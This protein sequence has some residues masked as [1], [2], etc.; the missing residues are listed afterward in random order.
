MQSIRITNNSV[1]AV[2]YGYGLAEL[3]GELTVVYLDLAPQHPKTLGAIWASLVNGARE[4]LRLVDENTGA[5]H[6]VRGLHRRYHRLAADA[7]RI[8]SRARPKHLRL[9]AP[10]ACQVEKLTHPF[11]ALSWSWH[12]EADRPQQLCPAQ[13]LA[14]ML[15][16]S[17]PLPIR[18]GWGEYLLA[19][20]QALD[21][22]QPVQRGGDSPEGWVIQ[23]APWDDI[24]S[25]GLR[26][27]Q[28]CLN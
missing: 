19:E 27:G 28:I 4:W 26:T 23:P 22:A 6:L 12:D 24:L 7:P 1:S 8:A 10:L 17:T 13:A 20:T 3:D 16:Q 21:L 9:V 11:V 25:R 15:E 2:V 5:T 14:A 18:M